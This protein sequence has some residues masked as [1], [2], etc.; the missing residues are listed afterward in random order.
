MKKNKMEQENKEQEVTPIVEEVTEIV[1]P[2]E[3][4]KEPEFVAS[5]F[6]KQL[7]LAIKHFTG[8]YGQTRDSQ[9]SEI[10]KQCGTIL[11][12]VISRV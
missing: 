12:K 6:V 10:A 2:I 11:Y 4:V 9:A 7:Q 3:E 8:I 5:E 1:I